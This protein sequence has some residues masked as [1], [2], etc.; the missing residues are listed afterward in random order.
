MVELTKSPVVPAPR[1]MT[2]FE[3]DTDR[4]PE[5]LSVRRAC[6]L[7]GVEFWTIASSERRRTFVSDMYTAC[8]V[9]SRHEGIVGTWWARGEERPLASGAVLL[10][11][12]GEAQYVTS[13]SASASFFIVCWDRSAIE[14]AAVDAG[15]TAGL[16][17]RAPY[18]ARPGDYLERLAALVVAPEDC[19]V[20]EEIFSEVTTH[21]VRE[22]ADT[23]ASRRTGSASHPGIRRAMERL[24][25]DFREPTSLD[26]LAKEAR[27]SKF[28]FVRCFRQATGLSPHRYRK[29]L[30]VLS[31]RRLLEQGMSVAEAASQ[32]SFADASH[33]SRTFREWLGVTPG[34]WANAWRA[35]EPSERAAPRTI[36]PP[37]SSE[38]MPASDVG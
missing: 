32:A 24:S 4:P 37:A 8:L 19:G 10:S 13:A 36:P 11:E 7:P 18:L 22:G 1:F 15:G 27:L 16:K 30:R 12:P 35:S 34:L 9:R 33:L 17:W 29:L 26:D 21:I 6:G 28:H 5:A 31:A 3:L 23:G 2:C 25:T 38:P 14:R 20:F